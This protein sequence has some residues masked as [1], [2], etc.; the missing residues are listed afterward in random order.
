MSGKMVSVH[1]MNA[2]NLETIYI[3]KNGCSLSSMSDFHEE[4]RIILQSQSSKY[5]GLNIQNLKLDME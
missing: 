1:G 3:R 5:D 4:V 2:L